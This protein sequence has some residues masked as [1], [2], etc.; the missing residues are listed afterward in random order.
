MTHV[1]LSI[2]Q[3]TVK[4]IHNNLFT[5]LNFSVSK[6]QHWALVGESGSGK[7]ALLQTI[8]GRFNITGGQITYPYFEDYK[9]KHQ[10]TDPNFTP[11]HVTALVGAT[12]HFKN[13]S[14]TNNFY[15]QQRFN[16]FDSEDAQTVSQF[17]K[18][19][20]QHYPK[21]ALGWN[22]ERVMNRLNLL[23][24]A[25]EQII[26]LSN[27]E[28][29]R[30]RLAA[31]LLKNP[32]LLL[33]D[34]P[35]NGLDVQRRA[36]FN[37]LLEEMIASGTSIILATA[38]DEIPDCITHVAHLKHGE[39]IEQR[40]KEGF[41][42]ATLSAK[43][44]KLNAV[45][46]DELK[47]LLHTGV[48]RI[49]YQYI[50]KM[51]QIHIQYGGKTILNNISWEVLQGERWA[52]L[53]PNGAG[54][55]TLLSLVNGDN[56]QAYANDIILFD[57]KRGSGESI[58]DI[59]SKIGFVSP[60]LHQYFPTENNCLQVIESGYNDT[61]GLF[62][63]SSKKQQATALQWMKT[64]TIEKYATT[65]FKNIPASAQRLCLLARALVKNPNLLIFDEPC[66]GLDAQQ[67]EHFKTIVDAICEL[68]NVTMVYVTH[69]QHEIPACVSKVIRLQDGQCV[70]N[71]EFI[72]G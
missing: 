29:K 38:P 8:A 71:G 30:L 56:P 10:I 65:L 41:L 21:H 20:E 26:K 55:S 53:G 34:N 28:T 45:D 35:L 12:H 67:Q 36:D 32:V 1:I 25:D 50:I 19:I 66:Q 49:V 17:L 59:K 6:G 18:A 15:Y 60:E 2:N 43:K 70:Q 64:L 7:S 16:S 51:N 9:Q 47:G 63:V 62:R 14:N 61:L 68:T 5:N 52:L 40:K 57:K 13:L 58:W 42:V 4:S 54:K 44:E 27:G 48:E 23:K 22:Y 69:Y 24:L 33:L 31:A 72:K 3:V 11:Q 46:V 37:L 39:I